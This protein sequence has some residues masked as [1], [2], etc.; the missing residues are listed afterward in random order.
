MPNVNH[1]GK[2]RNIFIVLLLAGA[3]LSCTDK[4]IVFD[5]YQSIPDAQWNR[6][7]IIHFSFSPIDTISKNNIYINLRNNHNYGYSNLFL[8]V[9]IDF[10]NATQVVDTLE[11][12]MADAEGKF[13]GTGFTDIKENKLE[14]KQNVVFPVKGIYGISIQQAMRKSGEVEGLEYLDGVSDI[15]LE[16]EKVRSDE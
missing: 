8:I 2:M 9:Q 15:G 5:K 14:Y 13:L 1:Q 12:E 7:S 4:N 6:D 10:P 11:Y 16:I 3:I